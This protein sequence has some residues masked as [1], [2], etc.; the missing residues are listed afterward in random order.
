MD[1]RARL[2]AQCRIL[3]AA[4]W[5]PFLVAACTLPSQPRMPVRPPHQ[6]TTALGPHD[7]N[8]RSRSRPLPADE[9]MHSVA[10]R[11]GALGWRQLCP[12][13]QR[14]VTRDTM[15]AQAEGQKTA[16]AGHVAKIQVDFVGSRP[17]RPAEQ[18]RFY[19]LT[20]DMADGSA[21]SRVY[22]VRTQGAGCVDGVQVDDLQ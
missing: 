4:S 6:N 2:L 11:D 14:V 1:H 9:F 18:I 15:R 22:I 7:R 5:L 12:Q 8:D 16:E 21:A 3:V 19:M 13:L 10:A 17:L 20:A